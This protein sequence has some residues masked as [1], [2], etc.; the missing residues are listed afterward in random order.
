MVT[1][2]MNFPFRTIEFNL[3]ARPGRVSGRG[4]ARRVAVR[5]RGGGAGAA[6]PRGGVPTR[7]SRPVAVTAGVVAPHA[8]EL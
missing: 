5:A 1:T 7:P 4:P 3:Y 8:H 2:H 6:G